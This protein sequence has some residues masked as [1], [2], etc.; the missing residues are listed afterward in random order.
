MRVDL[1]RMDIGVAQG[2]LDVPDVGAALQEVGRVAMAQ[3]VCR[4]GTR[5]ACAG[6]C[7]LHDH[8]QA[9]GAVGSVTRFPGKQPFRF[10]RG[11]RVA[12]G[13]QL[14][15]QPLGQGDVAILFPLSGKDM[16]HHSVRIDVLGFECEHFPE[17]Q[18]SAIQQHEHAAVLGVLGACDHCLDLFL[19]QHLG[20]GKRAFGA[21]Q[22]IEG[23]GLAFHFFI[24]E[25][26]GIDQDVLVG[27]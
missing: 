15:Q 14:G 8:L 18:P 5:D 11:H 10:F 4:D 16:D 20:Q 27:R 23:A 21:R 12:I 17:P 19:A 13:L 7:L 9:A 2:V 26:D 3:H 22:F 1:C 25:F 24:V 6:C